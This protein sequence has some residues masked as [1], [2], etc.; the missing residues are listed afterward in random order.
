MQLRNV[1]LNTVGSLYDDMYRGLLQCGILIYLRSLGVCAVELGVYPDVA[2]VSPS[3][4]FINYHEANGFS[5]S[6]SL[7]PAKYDGEI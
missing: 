2:F 3:N 6:G 4:S 7:L 5:R 1:F